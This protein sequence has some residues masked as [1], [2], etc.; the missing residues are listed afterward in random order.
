MTTLAERLESAKQIDPRST[1]EICRYVH[2]HGEKQT[3]TFQS[4][5]YFFENAIKGALLAEIKKTICEDCIEVTIV[6]GYREKWFH[7]YF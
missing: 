2:V 1:N 3:I 5:F 6:K 7:T 4:S